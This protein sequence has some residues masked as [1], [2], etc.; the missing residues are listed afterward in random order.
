[1]EE[2]ET[3]YP[4]RPES[5]VSGVAPHA[6][7]VFSGALAFA[8]IRQLPSDVETVVVIGGHLPPG[9][10]PLMALE[11]VY[12]TP[13]G[14]LPADTELRDW[15]RAAV[16]PGADR[17]PDNTVEVHLPIVRYLFPNARCLSLRCPPSSRSTEVGAALAEYAETKRQTIAVVG[18][19]D[20]THYGPDY[21]FEPEGRG[22][23]ARRW[24]RDVN[25][26]TMI[27]ALERIE[28]A[29]ILEAGT[30]HHAACSAGAANAAAVF[31][32]HRG[33]GNPVVI[34]HFTSYDVFPRD[35]FV[36][37]LGLGYAA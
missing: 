19:T 15:M 13:F 37:Y 34:D 20:L 17:L 30:R 1:M 4:T 10:A 22:E 36:G 8:V 32:Q 35:S 25:D 24:V 14:E 6:G 2:W 26:R 33:A 12:D 27:D 31:A 9:G 18:S 3:R 28:P 29:L 11:E 5:F 23:E 16:S 7:W 21:G